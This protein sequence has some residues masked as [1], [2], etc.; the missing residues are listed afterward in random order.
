MIIDVYSDILNKKVVAKLKER[1]ISYAPSRAVELEM[2][3]LK[4]WE[5]NSWTEKCKNFTEGY[6][7]FT[8][9]YWDYDDNTWETKQALATISE[10]MEEVYEENDFV[11]YVDKEKEAIRDAQKPDTKCTVVVYKFKIII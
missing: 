6:V 8:M 1:G 9:W 7:R 5:L 4:L 11:F 3:Y 2:P 10:I